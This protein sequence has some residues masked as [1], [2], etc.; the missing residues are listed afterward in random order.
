ME[1]LVLDIRLFGVYTSFQHINTP[2]HL[3]SLPAMT[4]ITSGKAKTDIWASRQSVSWVLIRQRG[5]NTTSG[6]WNLGRERWP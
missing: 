2:G 5:N 4:W 6:V 1:V 3:S